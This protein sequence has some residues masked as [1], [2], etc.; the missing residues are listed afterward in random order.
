[1]H[2]QFVTSCDSNNNV[3]FQSVVLCTKGCLIGVFVWLITVFKSKRN[4]N[5]DFMLIS[6]VTL[7]FRGVMCPWNHEVKLNTIYILHDDS[8][9]VL[10]NSIF[11][12]L[13]DFLASVELTFLAYRASVC[14]QRMQQRPD[15]NLILWT[16]ILATVRVLF[17]GVFFSIDKKE[18]EEI[19]NCRTFPQCFSAIQQSPNQS[20]GNCD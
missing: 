11:N 6:F 8:N 1:M 17:N 15:R 10:S 20:G 7:L 3:R 5:Y 4:A 2:Q 19:L 14:M 13:E 16:S 12:R 18:E 9:N